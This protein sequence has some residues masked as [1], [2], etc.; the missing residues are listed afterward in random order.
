MQ[1]TMENLEQ[2]KGTKQ[3]K[4]EHD[5]A[6]YYN[7]NAQHIKITI[8]TRLLNVLDIQMLNTNKILIE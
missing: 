1:P 8:K 6:R 3:E 2:F 5:L 7:T 4:M